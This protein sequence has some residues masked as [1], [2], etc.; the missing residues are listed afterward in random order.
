M[1]LDRIQV[2]K[3]VISAT[4]SLLQAMPPNKREALPFVISLFV[5]VICYRQI[6]RD[7]AAPFLLFP[8]GSSPRV[9]PPGH[10][11]P[12]LGIL[13][14][15]SYVPLD[16]RGRKSSCFFFPCSSALRILPSGS[17]SE[18]SLLLTIMNSL[19]FCALPSRY[20]LFSI[21]SLFLVNIGLKSTT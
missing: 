1:C 14:A 3:K 16:I 13:K 18:S 2:S 5:F 12:L 4:S 10:R 20:S 7:V 11:Q 9:R 17:A 6:K 15:A 21:P 19:V 8:R